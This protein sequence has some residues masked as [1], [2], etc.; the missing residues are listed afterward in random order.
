MGKE[1]SGKSIRTAGPGKASGPPKGRKRREVPIEE[2]SGHAQAAADH[3]GILIAAM[4]SL[5]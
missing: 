3:K 1:K 2:G 4:S 5:G